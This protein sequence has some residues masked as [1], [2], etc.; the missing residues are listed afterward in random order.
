MKC[1]KCHRV[2][3]VLSALLH[4]GAVAAFLIGRVELFA[5]PATERSVPVKLAMFQAQPPPPALQAEPVPEPPP[6][7]KPEVPKPKP[8]P[9]AER[10]PEPRPVVKEPAPVPSEPPIA[11]VQPV[12]APAA[13]Q[14]QVAS[15]EPQPM[16]PVSVNTKERDRYL[17]Q[18]MG[19]IERHKFYPPSARRRGMQGTVKVSF[20][21]LENGEIR[22][23]AVNGSHTILERAA[24]E[25]MRKAAPLPRPPASVSCP[26][27]V[28]FGMEF[29]LQ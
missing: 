21:L 12:S 4:L 18:L 2:G 27:R 20:V 9:K 16:P 13:E 23:L 7:P 22:D 6:P 24:A 15:A 1:S 11:A 26:H 3:L 28:Q 17:S 29:T 14:L 25:A 19:H 5:Q 10:K 8:K